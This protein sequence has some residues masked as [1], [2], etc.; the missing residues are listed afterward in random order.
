MGWFLMETQTAFVK[1]RSILHGFHYA[2][3]VIGM[4]AKRKEQMVVFKADIHKTFNT[5]ECPFIIKCL[6]ASGF[7]EKF[8]N[9]IEFLIMQGTSKVIINY[10]ADKNI[11]LQWGGGSTG[12]FYVPVYF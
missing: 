7:L 8:N 4:V 2:Q 1:G 5:I 11:V 3:E 9:W 6:K 10:V 12:R